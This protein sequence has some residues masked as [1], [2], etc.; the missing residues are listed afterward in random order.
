MAKRD[1]QR[2]K[3]YL[4]LISGSE[5]PEQMLESAAVR[6]A[7]SGAQVESAPG[8]KPAD[9]ALREAAT[10]VVGPTEPSPIQY[11][12]T[13]AIINEQFR[14]AIDI[15]G[16]DF[17][18]KHPLWLSLNEE[19]A[20]GRILK[21]LKSVGRIE[22]PGSD[23]PYGGTGF[24]VGER[25]MMTNRHVAEIFTSGL[26][27]RTLKFL[28]GG[29][30]GI[31][32]LRETG[33]A[34]GV[35]LKVRKVAMVH[36][37][38]DMA[39]LVVDGLDSEREPLKLSLSDARDLVG[40]QIFIVGYPAFDP[41]NPADVQD[42]LFE[43]RYGVKRLQPGKLAKSVT[44]ASF[45][46]SVNAAGHDCSTLGGNS[47]S[48][49]FSLDTGEV[50]ALHFGGAYH[51]VNYC[52]PSAALA[53]DSRVV[54]AG[55][56]FAGT[57]PGDPNTWG[58][59]WSKAD[60]QESADE[61]ALQD[62]GA[63]GPPGRPQQAATGA[64]DGG[65]PQATF[66]IP[67]RITVSIGQVRGENV[68]R[69][70]V[71]NPTEDFAETLK[72]PYHDS[73]YKSRTGYDPVFLGAD[74]EVAMPTAKVAADVAPTKDG[75]S[76]LPYQ[77]FSIAMHAKRRLALITASNVTKESKLRKP[78]PNADYTRKGLS[79]LTT[80]QELW[81]PDD[82]LEDKYQIPDV[83]FTKDQGAFDKGHIV[84]RDDVAWGKTY[85]TL[86][87]ANGDTYHVTNCSPQVAGFNRSAL[88]ETN[89][90]DLENYVLASA[91]SERLCVFAGP[92]L[93]QDDQTFVGVGS[94]GK[95]LRAKVP[96]RF[97][98]IIVAKIEDGIAV[99]GFILEQDLSAVSLEF[100]APP[101][102]ASVMYPIS[103]IAEQAGVVFSDAVLAGDQF[104][105][106]RG[107]ELVMRGVKRRQKD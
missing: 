60:S 64:L 65:N 67:L 70:E 57:A 86:R 107:T 106:V 61:T 58:S 49:V 4:R 73:N 54:G 22:L 20:R 13:E 37:Y 59:W 3:D 79:G 16:D 91:A 53:Q 103:E 101:E 83:F 46:K 85:A 2:L 40:Q 11:A 39:L 77:N 32:F 45:G 9:A 62:G 92:M 43:G 17:E 44:V 8:I 36:P 25:L 5:S 12:Q 56:E 104:E 14:P 34:E 1:P 74:A 24:V 93:A 51:Q 41:R 105:D 38:W 75:Q 42:A 96:S 94:D 31:N 76:V 95:M 99:F 98:K 35:T 88:G 87:R 89:W 52:V 97:W 66:E 47:G 28:P 55:V 29:S 27:V 84:R 82:R 71:V 72:A 80:E 63:K 33:G 18:V 69:A 26:G 100:V 78:D 23:I 19:P 50:L 7:P 90:G 6:L 10:W 21:A 48:A 15:K 102:F 68:A 81:Y 30:A